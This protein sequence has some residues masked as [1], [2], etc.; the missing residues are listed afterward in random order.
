MATAAKAA[1]I[2]ETKQA[3]ESATSAVLA[4]YRGLTVQQLGQLRSTLQQ[5]GVTLK[6]IKNTLIQRAANEVGIEGLE[7]YLK[8]PTAIAFSATDPVVAPKLMAQATREYR[9]MEIKG[10]ILG[11]TAITSQG[12]RE[13]AELPPRDVLIAKLAGTFAAPIQRLVWVANAPITNLAR[14]LDQVRM[15]K[16]SQA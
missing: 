4:D 14:V 16:Q 9:K 2:V 15:Q 13:L 1:T 10:G 12:V 6:V 11:L 7:P 3:L 5:S 8:G